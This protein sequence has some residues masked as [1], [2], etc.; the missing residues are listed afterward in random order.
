MATKQ[1]T[2]PRQSRKPAAKPIG[3]VLHAPVEAVIAA[4][5]NGNSATG[6]ELPAANPGNAAMNFTAQ[7][8]A[9]PEAPAAVVAA[10]A[11]VTVDVT[12]PEF[13]AALA[14]ALANR[15]PVVKKDAVAKT[16][17]TKR[18]EQNGIK[19]PLSGN[20][21]CATMWATFDRI[22]AEQG[23]P[24]TIAQAKAAMPNFNVVNMQGEYASWRKFNGIVGRIAAPAAAV[25]A[26]VPAVV[27][28]DAAPA[29]TPAPVVAAPAAE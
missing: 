1:A 10:P 26:A 25:A 15:V 21:I 7:Q 13:L 18:V 4:E 3:P 9:V 14:A 22:T 23:S 16:P 27:A 2:A 28:Q 11:V 6:A 5:E 29:E 12:S 20:G 17:R 19:R 8:L 24:C